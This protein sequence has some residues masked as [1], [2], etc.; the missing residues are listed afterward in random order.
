MT[1]ATA[2]AQRLATR[3][4]CATMCNPFG[5]Q[6]GD[7]KPARAKCRFCG[8]RWRIERGM[9]GVFVW[10]G[11]GFYPIEDAHSV[12]ASRLRAEKAAAGGEGE[13]VARWIP[14]NALGGAS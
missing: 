14:A 12:H 4:E 1:T 8:G 10:T 6:R 7:G 13:L 5:C 11:R 3:Y 2:T 9:W